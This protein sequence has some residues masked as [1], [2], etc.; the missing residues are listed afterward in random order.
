M[1]RSLTALRQAAP[2]RPGALAGHKRLGPLMV[3][4]GDHDLCRKPETQP[5]R[6]APARSAETLVSSRR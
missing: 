2:G 1:R 6:A 4:I 5:K 3:M